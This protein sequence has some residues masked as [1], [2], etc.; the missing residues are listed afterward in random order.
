MNF[1]ENISYES[2]LDELNEILENLEKQSYNI[3]SLSYYIQRSRFLLEF[4]KKK[5]ISVELE[6]NKIFEI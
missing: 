2:A 5:L 4:C 3:D 6:S 1:E